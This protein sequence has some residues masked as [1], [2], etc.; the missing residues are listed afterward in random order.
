MIGFICVDKPSG[1]TSRDV[2]DAVQRSTGIRKAGHAG[3]LD[4]MATGAVVVA[5]GGATRLIRFVQDF[6]KEYLATARFGVGTD[7]LDAQGEVVES[8]P[9]PVTLEDLREAAIGLT[10]EILQTPPMVSA[11]KVGGNRLY[12]LARQGIEVEREPR[13]VRVEEF[14]ILE[15]E[16]G[17][18][19]SVSMRVVCGKGTYVR[20]LADDLAGRFGGRAHLTSLRRTRIGALTL[21]RFGVAMEA[22]DPACRLIPPNEALAALPALVVDDEAAARVRNG[23]KLAIELPDGPTRVVTGSDELLAIYRRRGS[24]AVPEVVIS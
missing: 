12:D 24:V 14:E 8:S 19:P 5:V 2:V 11:V 21:D 6:D 23:A 20:V 7:T 16:E 10:G 15:A 9:L 13:P 17:D 22:L 18:F 4:P 1:P 3:T